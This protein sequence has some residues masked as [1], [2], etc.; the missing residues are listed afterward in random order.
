[1]KLKAFAG[2]VIGTALLG[3]CATT[4]NVSY[5]DAQ[6]VE[7][8]TKDFGSTD[9]QMIANKMVDDMLSF[10]PIVQMTQ[11]RRPVM[12]VDRIKNKTQEHIDTESITDTIQ[13]K[14][15]NSGKFRFVDMTA[16]NAM[17]EQIAYQKQSG[18]VNQA[19]SVRAGGQIGAEYM[20]NGNLSSIVKN[21]GGK[22]DV[23]YKF[24]LKLQNLQTGIVEWTNE[25]EIRKSS[26]RPAFGL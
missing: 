4:G 24:T 15:I 2:V 18:M 3:G 25:K 16:A 6:S 7:T 1:M 21:A 9:L 14:L 19:T 13:S 10:P 26:K 8:L 5:G 22:S 11:N 23:Y 12:F 20:L 17:A